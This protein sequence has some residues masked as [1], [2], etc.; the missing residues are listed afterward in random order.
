MTQ[1]VSLGKPRRS[2]V[3][4]CL[5][6]TLL[7]GCSKFDFDMSRNIPW[8]AGGDGVMQPP[9][10]VVAVWTDTVLTQGLAPATRGFGGRVMFYAVEGGKPIKVRG[11]LTVYAFDETGRDVESTKPDRK[12]IFTPEQFEKHYSKS[13]LGHSYSVWLPWDAA[14]GPLREISLLVRFQPENGTAVVGDP[15]KQHLPGP[16][17]EELAPTA[18]RMPDAATAT[19]PTAALPQPASG[20][21]QVSYEQPL[22]AAPAIDSTAAPINGAPTGGTWPAPVAPRRMTTTTIAIPNGPQSRRGT[23]WGQPSN[24][25][26]TTPAAYGPTTSEG[27]SASPTGAPLPTQQPL[28]GGPQQPAPQTSEQSST[29]FGPRRLRPLGSPLARLERDHVPWQQPRLESPSAPPS[30]PQ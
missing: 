30:A 7:A 28:P 22:G 4:A 8:G 15:A 5:A 11:T 27:R 16:R 20:V 19:V 10:K 17:Q 26:Q 1:L 6:A 14:G 13:A 12:F 2:V 23:T 24:A 21:Q 9:M 3:V 18:K 29:H 25:P